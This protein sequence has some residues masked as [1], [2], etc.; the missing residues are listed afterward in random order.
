ML[1][2]PTNVVGAGS[3]EVI[4]IF[5]GVAAMVQGVSAPSVRVKSLGAKAAT[6]D[7]WPPYA[8]VTTLPTGANFKNGNIAVVNG[9]TSS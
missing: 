3:T 8:I 4:G 5:S 9:V 7:T 6:P 1:C 2:A